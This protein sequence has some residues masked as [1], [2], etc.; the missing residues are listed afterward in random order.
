MKKTI[1][2]FCALMSIGLANA[3]MVSK[4][5]GGSFLLKN[6]TIHTITKGEMNGDVLVTGQVI[7][8]IGKG[9]TAPT[10]VK[11]IDCTGK[12][13][14]P[15][16][17]DA[18]TNLGLSEVS[19]VSLTNDYMEIGDIIPHMKALTAV[20]PNAT[21]IP[22]TRTNG[23]TTVLTK[24]AGGRI[25]GTAAII[26]LHGYTPEQMY[27]GYSAVTMNW[28][29][30]GRG[31][32]WDRRTDEEIAKDNEK[33]LKT[34]NDLW[35]NLAVYHKIDSLSKVEKKTVNAYK[36]E[37]DAMLPVFRG[38]GHLLVEVN[39]KDDILSALK[40]LG[41]KKVKG[42]LMG[43]KEGYMVAKE[44]AKSKIPVLV[45]PI[46]DNPGR[47]YEKYDV[48]YANPGLMAK[49]GVMLAIR[50]DETENVRNLPFHAGFAATY[51]LGKEKALEA[52]TIN[53]AKI[54]GIDKMY[55]S[56]EE[57][58]YANIIVTDGD[59]FEMKTKIS[60]VF[61]KGWSVPMENRHT[62]LYDEF[63][64]REPGLQLDK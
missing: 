36:P 58:K 17:I 1:Y 25:P 62:L 4:G 47:A 6:A 27:G 56:I 38:Q 53:P 28:P 33:S 13:I 23:V 40:W 57:G 8:S 35:D 26:N 63:L 21:A 64:T 34:I 41:E 32:R 14:Y 55:G 59:P 51:G 52:V 50:T 10:G 18:G 30:T 24:P 16:M 43:V 45:G 20:N 42:I 2:I 61:I 29:S 31:S 54:F 46:Q 11:V 39:K 7:K 19:S 12:H 60:Q 49:E 48:V 5:E 9:L 44:I 22:V 3:Q 15:G 37:L